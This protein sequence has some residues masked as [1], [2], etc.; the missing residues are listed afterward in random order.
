[1]GSVGGFAR[2]PKR[3]GKKKGHNKRGGKDGDQKDGQNSKK[4]RGSG[5]SLAPPY[6][7]QNKKKRQGQYKNKTAFE[8]MGPVAQKGKRD[9]TF[10]EETTNGVSKE[11]S[12]TGEGYSPAG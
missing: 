2:R 4:F 6:W 8:R 7:G 1:M 11:R 12:K 5:P 9:N 10:G 3:G